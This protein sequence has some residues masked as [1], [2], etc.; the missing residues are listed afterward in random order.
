MPLPE[1]PP[2]LT[3]ERWKNMRFGT[4]DIDVIV[5]GDSHVERIDV[6]GATLC[7]NPGSPT[8]PHNLNTQLGTIGFLEIDSGAVTASLW[9]LTDDGH[10]GPFAELAVTVPIGAS[11]GTDQ[12]P[13]GSR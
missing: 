11:A 4:Q 13:G 1:H 12:I 6:V 8:Y 9:Q 3:V 10:E 2:H 5:Y 7:V